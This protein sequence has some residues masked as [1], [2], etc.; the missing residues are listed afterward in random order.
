M[1]LSK[2]IESPKNDRLF[3]DKNPKSPE[4]LAKNENV[5]YIVLSDKKVP[6]KTDQKLIVLRN[7][8]AKT[9]AKHSPKFPKNSVKNPRKN[10]KNPVK[11]VPNVE[12]PPQKKRK[13]SYGSI[14]NSSQ[15]E[16]RISGSQSEGGMSPDSG[17][18]DSYSSGSDE[19]WGSPVRSDSCSSIYESSPA[20][21]PPTQNLSS[22]THS[23]QKQPPPL[24]NTIP[25]NMPTHMSNYIEKAFE[26]SVGKIEN[27]EE[28]Q[29]QQQQQEQVQQQQQQTTIIDDI[30]D[31]KIFDQIL[32][33]QNAHTAPPW[34]ELDIDVNQTHFL[35]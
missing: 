2:A 27:P 35:F 31:E 23:P 30:F 10:T 5:K 33:Q 26:L 13:I 12:T 8:S 3:A 19:N 29:Q 6:R 18:G 21:S 20:N 15:S 4:K 9:S 28:M 34:E 11:T 24:S 17:W 16:S 25:Q 7:A 1:Q 32:D 14:G 22:P